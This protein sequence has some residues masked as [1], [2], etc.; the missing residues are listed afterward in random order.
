MSYHVYLF[1]GEVKQ[2]Y[3]DVKDGSFLEEDIDFLPFTEKQSAYLT[4]N[5]LQ[6][7]YWIE[8]ENEFDIYFRFKRTTFA[9]NSTD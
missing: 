9:P 6:K 2:K 7:G 5:L 1:R 3:A 4:K 8:S